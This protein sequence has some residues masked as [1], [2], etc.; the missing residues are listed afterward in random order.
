MLTISAA[1]PPLTIAAAAAALSLGAAN[2]SPLQANGANAIAQVAAAAGASVAASAAQASV[3]APGAANLAATTKALAAQ[4]ASGAVAIDCSQANTFAFLLEGAAAFSFVNWPAAGRD[5]RVVVYC[6]QDAAGGRA[7]R[8]ASVK[9]PDGATPE[10]SSAPG[11][12]DCLVFDSFDGG[13]TIYGNLVG[14]DYA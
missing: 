2:P 6:V 4:P 14:G 10:L 1:A 7:A 13:A 11:A 3:A 12:V 5:Q 8:F 9:W